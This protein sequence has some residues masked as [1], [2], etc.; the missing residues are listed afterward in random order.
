MS[1]FFSE[2]KY[3]ASTE[4]NC[5]SEWIIQEIMMKQ[6]NLMHVINDILSH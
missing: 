2:L 3:T 1:D 5:G 6:E 4:E